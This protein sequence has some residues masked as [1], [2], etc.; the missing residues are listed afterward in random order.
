VPAER[1]VPI[2]GDSS[3]VMSFIVSGG[4]TGGTAVAEVR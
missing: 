1:V 2:D 3:E 4:V